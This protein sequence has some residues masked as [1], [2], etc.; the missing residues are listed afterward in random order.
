MTDVLIRNISDDD[1]RLL[2]HRAQ[3]FGVSRTEYLRNLLQSEARD[4]SSQIRL[5]ISLSD[6]AIFADLP[7]AAD[8]DFIRRGWSREA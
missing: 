2:D 7:D 8:E 4:E 5:D 1:V 6:F 3:R